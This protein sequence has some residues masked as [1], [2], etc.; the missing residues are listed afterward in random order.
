MK[1]FFKSLYL[2]N[3]VFYITIFLVVMFV[4][5]FVFPSIIWHHTNA[6]F[7]VY[8]HAFGG[9]NHVIPT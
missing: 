7:C 4:L 5:A 6:I 1:T 8:T 9:W 2:S 3:L